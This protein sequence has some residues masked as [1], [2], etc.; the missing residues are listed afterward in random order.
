MKGEGHGRIY[1]LSGGR[2]ALSGKKTGE[3]E[4]LSHTAGAGSGGKGSVF[5]DT[6]YRG[7]KNCSLRIPAGQCIEMHCCGSSVSG[8]RPD[9]ETGVFSYKKCMGRG[10]HPSVCV[11]KA[12]ESGIFSGSGI[13]ADYGYPGYA[14]YGKQKRRDQR[15]PGKRSRSL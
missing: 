3:N 12:G 13:L 5:C 7:R 6:G 11:Y 15:V 1:L 4:I 2:T 14:P 9:G 8:G 10:D